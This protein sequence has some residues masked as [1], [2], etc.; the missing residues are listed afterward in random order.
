MVIT[1][2]IAVGARVVGKHGPLEANPSGGKQQIRATIFGTVLR[3]TE[4]GEW[5]VCF[6]YNG[7]R[8]IVCN[9]TLKVVDQDSGIPLDELSTA[10]TAIATLDTDTSSSITETTNTSNGPLNQ[11]RVILIDFCFFFYVYD[12][13]YFT[14]PPSLNSY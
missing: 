1:N 5:E 14:A 8:K 3:A 4:K 9:N 6:D 12:S 11:V 7:R 10:V 2:R 13:H